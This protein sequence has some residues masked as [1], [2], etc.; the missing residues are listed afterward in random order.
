MQ[1]EFV[2]HA[3]GN[4][5]IARETAIQAAK[6][7]APPRLSEN[8]TKPPRRAGITRDYF[9]ASSVQPFA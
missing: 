6:P 9:S 8:R 4:M 1:D 5:L 3:F 7:C 2:R